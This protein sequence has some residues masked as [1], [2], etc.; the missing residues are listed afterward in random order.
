MTEPEHD[1][2]AVTRL[3]YLGGW[4]LIACGVL[5]VSLCGLCTSKFL[6]PVFTEPHISTG[7]V[8][9]AIAVVAVLGGLPMAAGA[10]VCWYGWRQVTGRPF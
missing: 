4:I 2:E 1:R 6:S 7:N 9:G 8:I 10:F 3:E 5:I